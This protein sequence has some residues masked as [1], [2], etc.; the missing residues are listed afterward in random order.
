MAKKITS[1]LPPTDDLLRRFGERLRLAR[2]R[3]RLTAR[4]VAERAG[5]ALM[6]LRGVERGGSGVT[7]GAYLAVMQV[8]GLEADL[9]WLA[10]EDVLGR[11]LQDARLPRRARAAAPSN[12]VTS[13]IIASTRVR[14]PAGDAYSAA[15]T[16][17]KASPS[18]REDSTRPWA[19]KLGFT[20]SQALSEL[21][22]RPRRTSRKTR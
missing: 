5:M 22:E 4:Q 7:M 8:L 17:S 14:E 18:K 10:K 16:R 9:E 15:P 19:D 6:T 13:T 3:R 20:Q 12:A 1:L 11:D 21:I 2:L